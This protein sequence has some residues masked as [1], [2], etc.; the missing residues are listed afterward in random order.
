VRVRGE[1]VPK[2]AARLE[3]GFAPPGAISEGDPLGARLP[4]TISVSAS[5]PSGTFA[6]QWV[7]VRLA[8]A[9]WLK[10]AEE[11]AAK[12]P[13]EAAVAAERGTA[14]PGVVSVAVRYQGSSG[15]I[16]IERAELDAAEA[17]APNLLSNGGFD[18][19]DPASW[20]VGW[21]RPE[22]YRYFPPALYYLFNTWHNA[23]FE[24]RGF[25]ALDPLIPRSGPASLKMVVPAGDEVQVI[26]APIALNQAEPRLIEVSAW[27]RTDQLNM[28]QIDGLSDTGERLD[29]F[30]FIHKAPVSIGTDGWR[31]LRQVFRPRRPLRS[32][33]LVLA[34]RG[35]NGYTL[36]DTGDT[37]Q[38]NVTGAI[39][40]DDVR[41]F[42]PESS[43]AD[44]ARRGVKMMPALVPAPGAPYL[45]DLDPGERLFGGNEMR[46]VIANPG[47]P[48]ALSLVWSFTTADGGRFESRSPLRTL[49]SGESAEVTLS[50]NLRPSLLPPYTEHKG[51]VSLV[52]RTGRTIAASALWFSTWST[53]VDLELGALYLGPEQK[54]FVRLNLGFSALAMT[55]TS[56]VRLD[57]IRRRTG[58]VVTSQQVSATLKDVISQRDRIPMGLREDFTNLLLTELDVGTLPLEPFES[59]ERRFF[60][61]AT[62]LDLKG[63][64]VFTRDS[65]PFCRQAHA[66]GVQSGVRSVRIGRDNLLSVN[67]E[68]FLPFDAVYGH[69]P[70][71]DGAGNGRGPYRNLHDLP[72]WSIYDGFTAKGY[73]RAEADMNA[74]RYVGGSITARA[75]LER[76]WTTENRLASTAFV[77]PSPVFS[78]AELEKAAGGE[79]ALNANLQFLK[80][81]PMV[82][83]IAPGIEEAF[84]LFHQATPAQISGLRD[85]VSSLRAATGKPVMVGHGGYWNR[86]EFERVPFFDIFDPETE[87]LYPA[88]L[89]TDLMPLVA[90]QEKAI[91]LRPQMY[92]DVPYE[93]W[94]F[95]VYVELM[96]GAR[97]FQIAHGPGDTSLFRGLHGELEGLKS[98]LW[99]QDPGPAVKVWPEM[100]HWVRRVSNRTYIMAATTRGLT[101]GRWKWQD[102]T[103]SLHGNARVTEGETV[104]RDEANSYGVSETPPKGP[105]LHG[106]QYLPGARR[107]PA[108]SKV[109]QW[110]WLDPK[111]AP[112]DLA[113]VAKA[114]G[115]FTHAAAWGPFALDRFRSGSGLEWFLRNFYRHANGFLGWGQDLLSQ[116]VPYVP[117]EARAMGALPKPGEW[118]RLEVSLADI[119]IAGELVDGIGFIHDGGRVFWGRTTIESGSNTLTVWGDSLG[120]LPESAE[121]AKIEVQGLRAGTRVK[122]L[123]EDREIVAG[124]GY[125]VDSF[126][127]QDLYQRFGGGQGA[128]YGDEPVAFHL[129]EIP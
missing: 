69:V 91:W 12:D 15:R 8:A 31:Q 117:R 23:R 94:R 50:Y 5:L 30:D 82:V 107:F 103:G 10:A 63:R 14:L 34:A 98:A 126:R 16:E 125:F 22:K 55:Q 20:P 93:R 4:A 113:L 71:Y 39:W 76:L 9:R 29:G 53:P 105:S 2:D 56:S 124:P 86:F 3:L 96:R 62:V 1:D 85:I 68:P 81:A 95:H 127:G 110:V 109:V 51:E 41:V 121:G 25:V 128:G 72:A 97:G 40:W 58:E 17:S 61:R 84:G 75:D 32:I 43:R 118:T 106:I 74:A 115:R 19:R 79:A 112:R 89:H 66:K 120:P 7:E 101:F 99:A 47:S 59:P 122:V 27:V 6:W 73:T 45:R 88:N 87:P 116:A 42:E 38:A 67:D 54:Q 92:E 44:L 123:F 48:R 28:L 13:K 114:D 77:V 83:S 111:A 52:D 108:G 18:S 119:G 90:G 24:N 129:Y 57:V 78:R 102:D 104:A 36:G 46:A 33:R 21:S 70:V 37:P 80:D 35:V 11:T 65:Q 49:A 64:S 26:S 100:E 60:V